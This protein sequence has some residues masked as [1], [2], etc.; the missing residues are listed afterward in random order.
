MAAWA[1]QRR[2]D[3]DEPIY[4]YLWTHPEPGPDTA[5][6]G[7][8][9]SSEIPYVFD[10][11]DAS[12]ERPFTDLDRR[13]AELMGDYW[14]NFVKTGNPNGQGLP[15]WPVYL[16]SDRQILQI[17]ETVYSRPILPGALRELFERH[18]QQGGRLT[19]F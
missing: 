17:G 6:Y 18:V 7:A 19:L 15:A 14:V 13:L 5:R 1:A 12:P 2:T 9:H 11:L 10:T 8:F 16:L 4:A 3:T